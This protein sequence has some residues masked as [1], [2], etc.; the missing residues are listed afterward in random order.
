VTS[1][2]KTREQ[3]RVGVL[4]WA[5]TDIEILYQSLNSLSSGT[6]TVAHREGVLSVGINRSCLRVETRRI[7]SQTGRRTASQQ[8]G[9]RAA[10]VAWL[11][12]SDWMK[13]GRRHHTSDIMPHST[14]YYCVIVNTKLEGND[15]TALSLFCERK[16]RSH[17]VSQLR[18][19]S[20][21]LPF[22]GV[23]VVAINAMHPCTRRRAYN[24]GIGPHYL[25]FQD[26]SPHHSVSRS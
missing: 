16:E 11:V 12:L 15:H 10:V 9:G 19:E 8:L 6:G 21:G 3:A 14:R 22:A 13:H 1:D 2:T 5:T 26:P 4:P 17:A 7:Y 23:G 25:P 24:Q 18:V 20:G